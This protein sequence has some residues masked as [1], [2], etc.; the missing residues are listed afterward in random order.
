MKAPPPGREHRAA[1]KA[2]CCRALGGGRTR[3]PSLPA[4]KASNQGVVQ[5]IGKVV[6]GLPRLRQRRRQRLLR[7][8]GRLLVSPRLLW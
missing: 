6:L 7:Q 1:G 4:S 5:R 2:G 3:R 8:R